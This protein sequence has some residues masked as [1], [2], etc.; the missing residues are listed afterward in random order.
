MLVNE[1]TNREET[2]KE[3]YTPGKTCT[4]QTLVH[5]GPQIETQGWSKSEGTRDPSSESAPCATLDTFRNRIGG[6]FV[7]FSKTC[8]STKTPLSDGREGPHISFAKWSK[9]ILFYRQPFQHA[10]PR[11]AVQNEMKDPYL[12]VVT[13]VPNAQQKGTEDSKIQAAKMKRH[14]FCKIRC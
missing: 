12:S 7:F 1:K 14:M 8:W 9:I 6:Y 2:H 3:N 13:A 4:G 11:P 10:K 5:F